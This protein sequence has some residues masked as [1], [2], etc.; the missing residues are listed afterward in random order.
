MALSLSIC[1]AGS[2]PISNI[3]EPVRGEV[4]E[5]V[6]R[7]R[8]PSFGV[9]ERAPIL[10]GGGQGHW[11]TTTRRLVWVCAGFLFAAMLGASTDAVAGVLGDM[12]R[13]A[14]LPRDVPFGSFRVDLSANL[15][16]RFESDDQFDVREYRP[17]FSDGFLLSRVM[18]DFSLRHGANRILFLQLR[19]ARAFD[20]KLQRGNFKRSNPIE[21][22][23]DIRQA[24][25][26]WQ[27]IGGSGIGF[28]VGRQQISYGDQRVFGPG[29]WGNTGRYVWDA[30]MMNYAQTGFKVDG[31]LGHIIE[32]RPELWPNR[33]TDA[34]TA[35]V[36]YA[37][38]PHK[39]DR[40]DLFVASKYNRSFDTIG[41]SGRGKLLAYYAGT[42][43]KTTPY[44]PLE[45][46]GTLVH[47]WGD[48]GTDRL[49]AWGAN[50]GSWL[51]ISMPCSIRFG[52]QYTHGSGDADP[53]D[54]VHGTFDGVFG[55]ADIN[56][57][58]D[59]NLFYW[60]NLQDYECDF[61]I[62]P[63]PGVRLYAEFHRY[64]L[65]HSKDAWYTTSMR[66]LA[67]DVNGMASRDLGSEM[68]FRMT[69]VMRPRLEWMCG[70]G[71][72]V[73]GHY[74]RQYGSGWYARW[75][76]GQVSWTV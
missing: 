14:V 57:Y 56:F 20:S 21:D 49:R 53:H 59:L 34:P 62:T 19:D 72:F 65:D 32:N 13:S 11:V 75:L 69:L 50:A 27:D 73:P 18:L 25:G 68:N 71:I 7:Q 8:H 12:G 40:W 55:G 28:R 76:F 70:Y 60:A 37:S 54:G 23:L 61:R 67:R 58:G 47:Q 31:W 30:A 4:N 10:T 41:E 1:R 16:M 26:E 33:A 9:S 39:A 36:I 63:R 3:R 38:F 48:Y 17:G 22:P 43:F 29:L 66:P 46:T 45:L 74:A 24:Y 52:A 15:R 5:R 44:Q 2:C 6:P 42:Q 51:N 64:L 35:M